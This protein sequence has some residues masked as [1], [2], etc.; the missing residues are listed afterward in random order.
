M[1]RYFLRGI[2]H[3]LHYDLHSGLN[4]VGRN[5]TN[6]FC[7][8]E[9]SVSSFHCEVTVADDGT[10]SVR[11]LQSTNGT[12]IDDQP[13]EEAP[14]LQG[15]VLQVGVVTLRLEGEQ[16]EIR[17]PP[18]SSP[19]LPSEP[20]TQLPDGT[21]CCHQNHE[22]PATHRCEK[23]GLLFN[24]ANLRGMRLSGGEKVLL[25]CPECNGQCVPLEPASTKKSK[26]SFLGRLTQTIRIPWRKK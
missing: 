12:F 1:L 4:T 7:I 15:Q 16:I 17:I 10:V 19:E 2:T 20:I 22:L 11:D 14:L 24:Q 23:C 13:V 5:P 18:T 6:D 8:H 3:A 9:V 26:P 21:P 25:F